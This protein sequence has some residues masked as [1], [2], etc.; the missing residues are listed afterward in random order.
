MENWKRKPKSVELEPYI[1][2][3]WALQVTSPTQSAALLL[4]N[5]SANLILSSSNDTHCYLKNGALIEIQGSHWISPYTEELYVLDQHPRQILGVKFHPSGPYGLGLIDEMPEPQKIIQQ[6]SLIFDWP[7]KNVISESDEA[8]E[9]IESK[10]LSLCQKN[11]DRAW[12][13]VQAALNYIHS[14]KSL[15]DLSLSR[16]TLE[17]HFALVTGLTKKQYE[18]MIRMDKLILAIFQTHT[19]EIDWSRFAVKFGFSDQP[20]MIRELKKVIGTTPKGY[21]LKRHL[22]IDLF[23]DFEG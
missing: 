16:R 4:P 2:N 22:L 3:I 11:N 10:L 9:I 5:V 18:Q 13:N 1:E 17:R 15:D 20:H 6:A 19:D 23:G 12:K 14:G 21:L 7:E 8:L